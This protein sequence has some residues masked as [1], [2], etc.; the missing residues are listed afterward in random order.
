[1]RRPRPAFAPRGHSCTPHSPPPPPP[2]RAPPVQLPHKRR[3]PPGSGEPGAAAPPLVLLLSLPL[4]LLAVSTLAHA[5]RTAAAEPRLAL[6]L[7]RN[8]VWLQLRLAAAAATLLALSAEHG[9]P[10][11]A[12]VAPELLGLAALLS[13]LQLVQL[14]WLWPQGCAAL[15]LFLDAARCLP[16]AL[17]LAAPAALGGFVAGLALQCFDAYPDEPGG[18]GG[19][20]MLRMARATCQWLLLPIAFVLSAGLAASSPYPLAQRAELERSRCLLWRDLSLGPEELR[21]VSARVRDMAW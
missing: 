14:G 15:A 4:A 20:G 16:S 11:P 8:S 13:W 5:Y 10:I 19:G 1:M 12:A 9:A 3:T 7:L 17:A 6:S 18:G 21:A 2:P